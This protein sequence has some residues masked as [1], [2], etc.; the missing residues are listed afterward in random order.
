MSNLLEA[1]VQCQEEGRSLCCLETNDARKFTFTGAYV[2]KDQNLENESKLE[3]AEEDCTGRWVH[4][5]CNAFPS[6]KDQWNIS[7]GLCVDCVT[8]ARNAEVYVNR[9]S[10]AT[11]DKEYIGM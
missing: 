9:V 8:N 11:E 5:H 7:E 2:T 6:S 4:I 1:H 3:V 10:N